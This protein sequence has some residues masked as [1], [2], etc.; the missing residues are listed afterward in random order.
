MRR[1]SGRKSKCQAARAQA[2]QSALRLVDGAAQRKEIPFALPFGPN[3][4]RPVPAN[5]TTG[6][7]ASGA[8]RLWSLQS[9]SLTTLLS[10]PRFPLCLVLFFFASFYFFFCVFTRPPTRRPRTAAAPTCSLQLTATAYAASPRVSQKAPFLWVSHPAD[11]CAR[12][13][14]KRQGPN[15][16]RPACSIPSRPPRLSTETASADLPAI[17]YVV[18]TDP[19]TRETRSPRPPPSILTA[20]ADRSDHVIGRGCAAGAVSRGE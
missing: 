7:G 5:Q 19:L 13:P 16:S 15:I 11:R 20:I 12:T 2:S 8:S 9:C 10:P 4:H 6:F 14:I 1:L 3:E 18:A 17:R